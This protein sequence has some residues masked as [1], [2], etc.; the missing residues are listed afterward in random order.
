M[1]KRLDI[2]NVMEDEVI[3]A[4]EEICDEEEHDPRFGYC[5]SPECRT[6]AACFV[7]NRVPQQYVSSSRGAAYASERFG[8]DAQ[9]RI[10]VVTL[11]HEGLARVSNVRRSYYEIEESPDGE[12][13]VG[14][15][16]NLPTIRGRLLDGESFAPIGG[17]DLVLLLEDAPLP[18]ID[19]RWANPF[20]LSHANPGRFYFRPRPVDADAAGS[21]RTFDLELRIDD[22]AYEPFRHFF[23]VSVRAEDRY[24]TQPGGAGDFQLPDLYILRA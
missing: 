6:D 8:L 19:S 15:Y 20:Q 13:K 4:V 11:V 18:M 10:D 21:D 2:H 16:F 7:L 5:T 1:D 14:V 24:V 22:D 23:R 17:V 3:R 9:L 12:R